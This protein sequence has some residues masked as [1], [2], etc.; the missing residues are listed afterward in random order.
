MNDAQV[1]WWQTVVI[2][3]VTSSA[4]SGIV[5]AYLTSRR[6][7]AQ[8]MREQML[9]AA[10]KFLQT[11]ALAL[12]ELD[13]IAPYTSTR[14]GDDAG[15]QL[16][17]SSDPRPFS[18]RLQ[19]LQRLRDELRSASAGVQLLFHPGSPASSDARQGVSAIDYAAVLAEQFPHRLDRPDSL[20]TAAETAAAFVGAQKMAAY[21]LDGFPTTAWEKLQRPLAVKPTLRTRAR[22]LRVRIQRSIGRLI[23]RIHHS[24][25]Q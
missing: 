3:V 25:P 6:E 10:S 18:Q 13:G 24:S 9:A 8:Q 12:R 17:A 20:T 15:E 1:E 7:R 4:V 21:A 16:A 23:A 2:A 5:V 11:L 22:I 14:S 19:E